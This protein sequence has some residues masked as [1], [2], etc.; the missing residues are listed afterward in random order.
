MTARIYS[1]ARNA[2]Q[3]GTAKTGRWL[4]EYEPE[5]PREIEPL[6]GWTSS[7]DMKSQL[8]LWF[9]TA[10]EAVAYATRNGIA[11]RLEQ[12]HQAKRR[13]MAYADNFKFNRVGQW[14][15]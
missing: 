2:M 14:T 7:G 8:R 4:L 15:H 1:P 11:Y 10:E 6:M 5:R 12:P 9:D 3:S 13:S